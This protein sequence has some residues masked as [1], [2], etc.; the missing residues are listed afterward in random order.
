VLRDFVHE[1]CAGC[2][3]VRVEDLGSV[4]CDALCL[5]LLLLLLRILRRGETAR[6]LLVELGARS[7]TIHRNVQELLGLDNLGDDAVDVGEHGQHHIAL[8]QSC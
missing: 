4:H 3:A 6:P 1:L 2:D 8:R 7:H 5:K